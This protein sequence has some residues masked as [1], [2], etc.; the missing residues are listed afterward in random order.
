LPSY[1]SPATAKLSGR[2]GQPTGRTDIPL[3]ARGED[4]ARRLAPL[5]GPVQLSVVLCSPRQRARCTCEL[6]GLGAIAGTEPDLAEWEY[7]DY[8]VCAPPRSSRIDLAGTSS[9]TDA[10]AVTHRPRSRRGPIG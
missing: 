6:G 4:E 2:S 8:E 5:N 1:T 7:G 10:R 3:T 9:P